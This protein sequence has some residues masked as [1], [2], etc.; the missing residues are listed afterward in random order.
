[1]AT[2]PRQKR[3][4]TNINW[5]G[6]KRGARLILNI[7]TAVTPRHEN[8]ECGTRTKLRRLETRGKP[9]LFP[10]QPFVN[11][12][13]RCNGLGITAEAGTSSFATLLSGTRPNAYATGTN[14]A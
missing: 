3:R 4:N 2:C 14:G 8:I 11:K 7:E 10:T 6:K 1:M 5:N 13:A 12:S 9:G